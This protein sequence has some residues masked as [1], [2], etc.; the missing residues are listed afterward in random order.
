LIVRCRNRFDFDT[1]HETSQQIPCQAL[2]SRLDASDSDQL[3]VLDRCIFACLALPRFPGGYLL[4]QSFSR[5]QLE[6]SAVKS[7]GMCKKQPDETSMLCAR[8]TLYGEHGVNKIY[9]DATAALAGMVR[10]GQLLAV[11]G[12]GLCG[13]PEAL[14]DALRDSGGQEPDGDLQQCRCGRLWTWASCWKRG[15]S[16]K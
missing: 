5:G 16:R 9:P 8:S 13:I 1:G 4:H 14:I 15:K 10:D 12:F 3:L 2:M 6:Q 7:A 11:G